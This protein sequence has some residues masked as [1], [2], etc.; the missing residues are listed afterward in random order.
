MKSD[1]TWIIE[2]LLDQVRQKSSSDYY[3]SKLLD[4]F[5]LITIF[6]DKGV[7][8]NQLDILSAFQRTK[9]QVIDLKNLTH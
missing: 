8:K 6:N 7:K 2:M 3:R 1:V 4:I 9:F 5:R